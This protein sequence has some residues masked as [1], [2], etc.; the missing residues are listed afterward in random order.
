M[1]SPGANIGHA[2]TSRHCFAGNGERIAMHW[3]SARHERRSFTF[4]ELD[5][6]SGRCS[7]ALHASGLRAGETMFLFLPKVPELFFS[8]LG[9]LKHNLVVGTLFANIGEEAMLDRLADSGAAAIFIHHSYLRKL[10][11][12]RADLP[13]LRKVIVVGGEGQMAGE[14]SYQ[15]FLAD[16]PLSYQAIA[17][18]PD[19]PSVLHYTSGSTGKPKGVL[20]CHRSIQ[21]Q[22]ATTRQVLG[23]VDGDIYWC[24]AEQG[25]VTGTSYGIIGPWGAGVTQV[26]FEGGY[27]AADWL[28]VLREERVTVWYT[29]P[30]ALRM[31]MREPEELF[32]GTPLPALRAIYSVGEPLNPEVVSWCRSVLG[33]EV[34]DTWFQTET[35]G[36]M[37][38]N[39]PGVTV[40]P[41]SMGLPVADVEA[42]I[43]SEE[44]EVLPP[45]SIGSLAVKAG[46]SSMF[47]S[48][49]NN[50]QAY[51]AKFLNGWYLTGDMA[52][53]D[54]EGYFHFVG[55]SDD[56]INTAGHLVSPFEIESALLELPEVA[57]SAAVALPDPLLFEKVAVFVCL[58]RDHAAT[59]DLDLKIRLHVTRKVSSVATPQEVV[60]VD[61]IPRNRSGKIMRRLLRARHLGEP[62]GDTSTLEQ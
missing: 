23:L 61:A 32:R 37:I 48:Y 4:A 19:T 56:V 52:V 1:E 59:L 25:W 15:Q 30:T 31:L 46:W 28:S 39:R 49:L 55:R 24:T 12:I 2:C 41:G 9:G 7:A 29:A 40:K 17:T 42:A 53:R 10:R 51:Q 57:E 58:H 16:A 26:H 20:H 27:N 36:I 18:A 45:G 11:K 47:V 13:L 6:E 35:G 22:L 3:R 33:K 60:F 34:Y 21:H 8:F 54:G 5:R 38:A 14:I 50:P 43:V 44:G 62:E